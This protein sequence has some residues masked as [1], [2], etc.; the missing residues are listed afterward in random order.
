MIERQNMKIISDLSDADLCAALR[1]CVGNAC[2]NCPCNVPGIENC[3]DAVALDA[4]RRLEAT[5]ELRAERDAMKKQL[6]RMGI[7]I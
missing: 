4:A 2:T 3:M 6:R 7:Q 5:I 1:A